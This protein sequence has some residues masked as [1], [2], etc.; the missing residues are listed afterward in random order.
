[1]PILEDAVA[2]IAGGEPLQSFCDW[3]GACLVPSP[4]SAAEVTADE[5][6]QARRMV[7]AMARKLW[8]GVP[9][10]GQHWR[11]HSLPKQ[12]R[13]AAC[14]CGSGHKFKHCCADLASMPDL[15][16]PEHALGLVVASMV[17]Q[18]T[19]RAQLLQIP[20]SA[21]TMAASKMLH[22]HGPQ[23]VVQ[24]LE[25]LFLESAGLDERHEDAFELLVDALREVG[26]EVRRQQVVD[27]ISASANKQLA[28]SA[29]GRHVSMLA[30]RGD[31]EA[32]WEL[33]HATQRL[34]PNDPQLLHLEL[35]LLL[36]QGRNQE[37]Q[38]RGPLLAAKARKLGYLELGTML[39][40]LARDGLAA[41]E[42]LAPPDE[43]LDFEE[44][45]WVNLLNSAP[46]KVDASHCRSL[47]NLTTLPP[48][49]GDTLP[50]LGVVPNKALATTE[51][52]WRKRFP[53]QTP[54]LTDLDGD[55][56]SVL[57]ETEAVQAFLAEYP[58]AWYSVN[59]L[60]D[61]LLAAREMEQESGTH[62]VVLGARA[63]AAHAI[64]VCRALADGEPRRVLW[65]VQDSRPFLRCIAQAI[66][67]A[68]QMHDAEAAESLMR[69]SL[70]LN[71]NDNHGWRELLV[72]SCLQTDR[73]G[74]A[75]QWLDRYP[76]DMVPAGHNRAL[77]LFALD[78]REA[79]EAVLRQ[80]HDEAPALAVALLPEMLDAPPDEEGPG[81]ILGGALHAFYYRD[82]MRVTWVQTGALAWLRSLNLPPPKPAKRVKAAKQAKK[83]KT[84]AD[85]RPVSVRM[86]GQQMQAAA[87]PS[88]G[89]IE[90]LKADFPDYQRLHGFLTAIAWSPEMAM[91]NT[92]LPSV[93]AMYQPA[94]GAAGQ[95]S[96]LDEMNRVLRDVT[97]LSN[98][99]NSAVLSQDAQ[100]EPPVDVLD[101]DAAAIVWSAGFVQGAEHCAAQW[102]SAGFAVK[103]NKLPFKALYALAAQAPVAPGNWR[104][105]NDEEQPLLAGLECDPVPVRELLAN[106]LRTLWRGI[107]PIRQRRMAGNPL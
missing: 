83:G 82:D 77:A 85:E 93:L 68:R 33:F 36:S 16:D 39:E 107:A 105:T 41:M 34:S 70:A 48:I 4:E 96:T 75:L 19:S 13:N 87:G 76:H 32:A 60:D 42:A 55:A 50:V 74:E 52:R 73:A 84:D 106:A 6:D 9:L 100:G 92:W 11:R 101:T 47:H 28:T 90:R 81:V 91:P 80:A 98:H 72:Q 15:I 58:D 54:M 2:R 57:D 94:S 51:R 46:A 1:M 103:H 24:W 22:E 95:P 97:Q 53:V 40:A 63:L 21:L 104:A 18:H 14:Y 31:Y 43:E 64:A 78:Q 35:V 30:D 37:A 3:F 65:G 88:D 7:L 99:L 10:P 38:L 45:Q 12:E 102:R 29:R 23:R 69:W 67:F 44:Q 49:E 8:S 62:A 26:Q 25:P 59:V 89:D 66:E 86:L 56:S 61:L 20:P 5:R 17:P 79:A 71:P 27:V